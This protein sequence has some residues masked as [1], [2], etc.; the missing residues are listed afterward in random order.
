MYLV[1]FLSALVLAMMAGYLQPEGKCQLLTVTDAQDRLHSDIEIRSVERI[2]TAILGKNGGATVR[3]PFNTRLV[4]PTQQRRHNQPKPRLPAKAPL[5]AYDD[6]KEEREILEDHW[7]T[8]RLVS[9]FAWIGKV[10]LPPTNP[11]AGVLDWFL[12]KQVLIVG[13]RADVHSYCSS[14]AIACQKMDFK[15]WSATVVLPDYKS[16]EKQI[17]ITDIVPSWLEPKGEDTLLDKKRLYAAVAYHEYIHVKGV[18]EFESSRMHL[19]FLSDLKLCREPTWSEVFKYV[20]Q[21]YSLSVYVA[22]VLDV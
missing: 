11:W 13:G 14:T 8:K 20:L 19:Q 6:G 18:N 12:S 21:R 16:F 10:K 2:P 3:V 5:S 9:E 4:L 22:S 7:D 1:V 17:S 15:R